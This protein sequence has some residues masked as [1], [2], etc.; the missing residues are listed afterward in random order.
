MIETS[1]IAER[2]PAE[3]HA[4]PIAPDRPTRE[5][6]VAALRTLDREKL[7]YLVGGG[8][9]MAY[10]TGIA[11]NT[12]DLDIFIRPADRDRSLRILADAGYRTEFF[13]PFWISKALQGEAFID[14]LYNS[15]NGLSPVDDDWFRYAVP[16]DVHGYPTRLIPAEEQIWSKAFVQDRDRFDGADVNHLILT[17]GRKMDW[18]RLLR[19]FEGHER[20]LLAHVILFGYAY[21]CD[22]DAVPAWAI[23]RLE[24]AVRN[25]PPVN[26]RLCRGPFLAQKGYG[27]ALRHWGYAD[28][29]LQPHG[30]LTPNEVAQLPEA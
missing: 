8:Y 1:P 25:E 30:P 10:Y 11:R 26:Q 15:G 12:K 24:S 9:A 5:F 16:A 2:Q 18:R 19:R 22:R 14:I 3:R 17:R 21:P 27:T 23:E 6:Y 29:R 20:V 13:Y 4:E 7:E 28:A